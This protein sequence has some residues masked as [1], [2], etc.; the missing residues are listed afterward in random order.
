MIRKSGN[1]FSE[2]IML[3]QKDRAPI[4]SICS[5]RAL[6]RV[7]DAAVAMFATDWTGSDGLSLL[8]CAP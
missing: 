7:V 6:E 2:K 8:E 1:R 4:D 5:H 3:H